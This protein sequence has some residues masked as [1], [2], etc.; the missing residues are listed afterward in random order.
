VP[1][2][3]VG[4]GLLMG[5]VGNRLLKLGGLF[6][7]F[8]VIEFHIKGCKVGWLIFNFSKYSF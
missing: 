5:K 2:G 4:D 1:G 6:N 8:R 7:L 3:G